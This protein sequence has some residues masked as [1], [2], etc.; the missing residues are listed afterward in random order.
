MVLVVAVG[1]EGF[2]LG[3]KRVWV[4]GHNGMVGSALMRR[5]ARENCTLL[6]AD[7]TTVDLTSQAATEAWMAEERPEVVFAAAGRVGGI[8]A[9]ATHPAEFL[10]ENLMI[11]ANVIHAAHRIGVEKLLYLGSS[12]IYPRDTAQPI[13]ESRLLTGPLEGTNEAYAIAKIA[14]VKLVESYARQYGCRFVSAMPTNLYGPNDNFDLETSHVLPALIRR[15]HEAKVQGQATVTIW[16][17]GRPR[18]EF[19]HVDD[20]ADA[21]VA[22]MKRYDN[23]T[24]INIGSGEDVAIADL[25]GLV[26]RVVGYEG[27]LAFDPSRPDGTPRKLLDTTKLARLGWR[28]AIG[29]EDGIRDTLRYW[30]A[31]EAEGAGR[32]VCQA[33]V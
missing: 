2:D 21:C 16:G 23:P 30:L 13:R 5:L 7:R 20:L 24:P 3:G 18:R 22:V 29:L 15:I 27:Q 14:G 19:L 25:A 33:A 12:C 28:P 31:V 32:P 11:A 9:N 1:R 10:Y 4:T 17:S 26:A 8:A 6:T